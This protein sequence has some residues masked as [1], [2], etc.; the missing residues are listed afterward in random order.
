MVKVH[1]FFDPMC[2]W[3]YGASS[4]IAELADMANVEM[5][6]HPGGMIEKQAIADA[7]RQ[8]ILHADQQ[9][10]RMTGEYFGEAYR[11]R[12]AGSEPFVID[13]YLPIRAMLVG[14]ELGAKP[15][16]L[17]KEIQ[18]AH[19]QDGKPVDK[20][21]ALEAIA[22]SLGLDKEVWNAKMA[23]Y[24]AKVLTEVKASHELMRQY[25]VSGYPTLILE[26]EG[27]ME[28][29]DHSS[30]YGKPSMWRSYIESVIGA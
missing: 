23:Q 19:Y 20:A 8:H 14:T 17:L 16:A 2:G 13:S 29:L 22:V 5:V 28:R 1:Y 26:K 4:L 30:Y 15:Q 6:Y 27:R 10:A 9:I 7:F 12:V 21:E 11:Q 18:Q 25:R 3:C 24:D